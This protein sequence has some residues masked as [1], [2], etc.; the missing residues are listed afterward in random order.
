M[1]FMKEAG[2]KLGDS[3]KKAPMAAPA[4]IGVPDAVNKAAFEPAALKD[5]EV[6][7]KKRAVAIAMAGAKKKA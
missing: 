1:D 6:Q 3:S 7:D 2:K 5:S 4:K